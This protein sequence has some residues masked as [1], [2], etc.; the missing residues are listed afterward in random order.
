MRKVINKEK[1]D[2]YISKFNINEI[3]SSDMSQ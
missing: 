3:F 2:F 1:L